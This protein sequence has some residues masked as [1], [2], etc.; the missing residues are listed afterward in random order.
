MGNRDAGNRTVATNLTT[1]DTPEGSHDALIVGAG[2]AGLSAALAAQNAGLSYLVIERGCI[3]HTIYHYPTGLLFYSTPELIELGDIPLIVREAKPTREEALRY[4]RR[5]VEVKGLKVHTYEEVTEILGS[6]GDFTVRTHTDGAG[7]HAY[8][9]RKII[10]STGAFDQPKRI[11][12]PGENLPKVTHYFKEAHPYYDRD[13]LVVG[14]KSSAVETALTL[15][16][17]GARVTLSYRRAEFYG[18][19]YWVLPDLENRIKEGSIRAIMSSTVKEIRQRDVV[20]QVAD[21]DADLVISNDF[22]FCMTGHEP[23][24]AFLTDIGVEVAGS[25]RRPAHDQETF[26]SNVPG[27][28]VIGVITAGN[29]GNEVFIENSRTHG[30]KVIEHITT[31]NRTL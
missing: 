18:I 29:I 6:D 22:V 16:R 30:P 10:L 13:V 31:R 8:R 26:E 20:L 14:G 21:Q 28:Y 25:D 4:Y 7:A 5:F 27:V 9:T 3:V 23:D 24:V 15:F 11:N 2:P 19:K 1:D 12:V 17:S